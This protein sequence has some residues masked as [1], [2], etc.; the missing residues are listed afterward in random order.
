MKNWSEPS[1]KSE[2]VT[3]EVLT[4]DPAD[5][6]PRLSDDRL[7]MT[8]ATDDLATELYRARTVAFEQL[9]PLG[10]LQVSWTGDQVINEELVRAEW[11]E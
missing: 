7:A 11:E 9:E 5:R 10:V 6:R 3:E 4:D 8:L 2:S 1:G